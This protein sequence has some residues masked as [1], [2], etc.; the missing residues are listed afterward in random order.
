LVPPHCTTNRVALLDGGIP[1]P[2][3]TPSATNPFDIK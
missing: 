1:N 3:L 2:T